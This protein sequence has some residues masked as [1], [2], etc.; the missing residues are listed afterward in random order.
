MREDISKDNFNQ[1]KRCHKRQAESQRVHR[2]DLLTFA[3]RALFMVNEEKIEGR[4]PALSTELARNGF[5]PRWCSS[6]TGIAPEPHQDQR[7]WASA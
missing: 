4:A 3:K 5:D 6:D 1:Q 7:K 2:A